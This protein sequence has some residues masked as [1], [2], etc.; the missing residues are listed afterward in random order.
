MNEASPLAPAS[1]LAPTGN[2]KPGISF[3]FSTVSNISVNSTGSKGSSELVSS[4]Q[5]NSSSSFVNS[6]IGKGVLGSAQ[7]VG[8]LGG[9]QNSKKDGGSLSLKSS[10]FTSGGSVPVKTGGKNEASFGSN[11]PQTSYTTER[12]VLGSSTG[13]SSAPSPSISPAKLLPV[14]SSSTGFRTGNLEALPTSCGSHVQQQTIGKSHNNR[15]HTSVDYTRNFKLG[16]L[17]DTEQDLSKKFYSVRSTENV[18][19]IM[20]YYYTLLR[21]DCNVL[22]LF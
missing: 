17:F 21:P 8:A 13:L 10:V 5:P 3:S 9:S 2:M 4:W 19:V 12:K 11:L 20:F 22:C 7:P 18:L 14:E 15:T 16:T 6:Q 1:S